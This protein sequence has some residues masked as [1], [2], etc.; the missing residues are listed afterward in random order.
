MSRRLPARPTPELLGAYYDRWLAGDPPRTITRA[1]LADHGLGHTEAELG[2]Y[3]RRQLPALHAYCRQRFADVTSASLR[4]T[5]APAAIELTAD[6]REELVRYVGLGATLPKAAA[7]LDVPLVT[8]TELWLRDDPAL[9]AEL[10]VARDRH[11]LQV[12]HALQRRALGYELDFEETREETGMSATG[13]INRTVTVKHTKHLPGSVEAQKFWLK[14]RAGW[15]DVP[16][17]DAHD[18]EEVEYDVRERLYD[19]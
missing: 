10:D 7:L 8:V 16:A 18:G 15:S 6:R 2:R 4:E 3:L 5:G 13:A 14:N 1:L 19:E 9:R 11:D 12:L 17:T